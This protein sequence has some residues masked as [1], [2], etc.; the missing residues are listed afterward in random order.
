MNIF[1]LVGWGKYTTKFHIIY[2]KGIGGYCSTEEPCQTKNSHC[3]AEN[4]CQCDENYLVVDKDC[5]AG[6]GMQCDTDTDCGMEQSFCKT[7]EITE[8]T[9]SNETE[10]IKHCHCNE[11]YVPAKGQCSKKGK[12]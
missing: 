10:E 5:K 8:G 12:W 11:G 1:I 9:T 2:I 3:T 7:I 6:V 4:V